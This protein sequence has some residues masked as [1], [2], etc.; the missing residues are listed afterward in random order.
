MFGHNS[1][2]GGCN[3]K[4]RWYMVFLKPTK[5]EHNVYCLVFFYLYFSAQSFDFTKKI[6]RR[7]KGCRTTAPLR[8]SYIQGRSCRGQGRSCRGQGAVV[9]A[10][11]AAVGNIGMH[12]Y[13]RH[14]CGPVHVREILQQ[15]IY[16]SDQGL[17]AEGTV[18]I[19][20]RYSNESKT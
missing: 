2:T 9:G 17:V 1:H 10:R 13:I 18:Y 5:S 8:S 11:G 7:K 16:E 19:Y 6:I 4:D 20:Y 12:T 3:S 14:I 15:Y